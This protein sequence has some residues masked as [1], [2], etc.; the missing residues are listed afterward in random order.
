MINKALYGLRSSG[1]RWHEKLAKILLKIGF[2]TC[3][4]E[5]DIWMR[6][7]G[8]KYEYIAVYV[9]DLAIAAENLRK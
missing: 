4:V 6:R 8:T 2:V 9:D 7:N 1:L 5:P 3:K